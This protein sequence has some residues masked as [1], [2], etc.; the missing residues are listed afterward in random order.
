MYI[1][2]VF[3]TRGNQSKWNKIKKKK[4]LKVKIHF[5][6]SLLFSWEL[7]KVREI[8]SNPPIKSSLLR[9]YDYSNI[10]DNVKKQ[11]KKLF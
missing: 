7:R 6:F 4:C 11:F 10:N 1:Y 2:F 5:H 3:V 9:K 8:E